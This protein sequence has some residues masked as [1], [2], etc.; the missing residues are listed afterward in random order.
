MIRRSLAVLAL[1]VAAWSCREAPAPNAS[2]TLGGR[3]IP[4]TV[5]A[6]AKERREAKLTCTTLPD[7][8]G[9]LLWWPRERFLKLEPLADSYDVVFLDRSGTVVDI[10]RLDRGSDEGLV[11]QAEA[12]G[13]LLL[14]LDEPKK[15]GIRKG[16]HAVLSG[17][18]APED[19][20]PL[21]IGDVAI[22][23]ELALTEPERQHGL[24]FR[25]RM[26]ADEGMLFGY[27]DQA[28]RTFW[29]MNTLI[30]LD[31]AFFASDGTL[32]NVNE[33]PTG[34]DPR[35]EPVPRS[36]SS[37]P[38]RFVLEMNLGWFK[39]KGLVDAEGKVKPGLKA[40]FPPRALNESLPD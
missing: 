18:P 40:T 14:P 2:V 5:L 33:T 38:A 20:A 31:I 29:M 28:P 15:T 13:A 1:S 35:R 6:T 19:L 7:G 11:P 36:P 30:P 12:A 25:P 9:Y 23:V 34:A 17:I 39:R 32:L 24:M 21:T 10:G 27:P 8:R 22:K 3:P 4:V 16:D 37:G 26:S